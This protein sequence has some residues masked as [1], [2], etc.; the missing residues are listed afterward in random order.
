[1]LSVSFSSLPLIIYPDP[2][3]ILEIASLDGYPYAFL[4]KAK[5]SWPQM[6]P[7]SPK[8]VGIDPKAWKPTAAD[9]RI[10][11]DSCFPKD[12]TSATHAFT[13][14]AFDNIRCGDCSK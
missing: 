13:H 1:M 14:V 11:L 9:C 12:I 6:T 10:E 5:R 8:S 4:Y 3:V 7:N 2:H